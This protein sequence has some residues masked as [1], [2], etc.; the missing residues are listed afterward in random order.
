[1]AFFG[2]LFF[3]RDVAG[4]KGL[5]CFDPARKLRI[6]A[7]GLAAETVLIAFQPHRSQP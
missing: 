4:R 7:P 5:C 3:A 6:A 1:M 2:R